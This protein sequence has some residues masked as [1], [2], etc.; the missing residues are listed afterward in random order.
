MTYGPGQRIKPGLNASSIAILGMQGQTSRLK[1]NRHFSR[2][3][4]AYYE[5]HSAG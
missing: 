3:L 2:N 4:L 5:Q 1:S